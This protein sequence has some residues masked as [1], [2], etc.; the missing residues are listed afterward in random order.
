MSLLTGADFTY[1]GYYRVDYTLGNNLHYGHA[2]THRYVSGGNLRFLTFSYAPQTSGVPHDARLVEFAPPAAGFSGIVTSLTNYWNNIGFPDGYGDPLAGGFVG[3]FWD[4]PNN[5]LW[6][7]TAIRYPNNEQMWWTKSMMYRTLNDDGTVSNTSGPWGMEGVGAREVYGGM[8]AVPSGFQAL[9]SGKGVGPYAAGYGG[10]ASVAFQGLGCSF[11]LALHSFPAPVSGMPVVSGTFTYTSG[12]FRTLSRHVTPTYDW[13]A[14][15]GVI[16]SG[17][18]DRQTRVAAV[19]N[20]MEAPQWQSPAPDDK[21]RWTIEDASWNTGC[22][23]EG[24]TKKGFVLLGSLATG[25]LYYDASY[26]LCS[27]QAFEGYIFDPE[28]FSEVVSGMRQPWDV[29]PVE[30]ITINLP[31][32]TPY[33]HHV[34]GTPQHNL[35]GA[36]YDSVAQRLYMYMPHGE[37]TSFAWHSRIY[38]F[39]VSG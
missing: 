24:P 2:F 28:H 8:V 27:G 35:A 25:R 15:G 38:V 21:G 3:L 17:T 18:F 14:S 9:H 34:P 23:I 30:T 1:L 16:Y 32:F 39:G 5:R 26:P 22:W 10:V 31:D 36:S 6:T 19:Q 4:E 33:A 13:Y 11:G 12:A 29:Q 7:T 20:D 37:D